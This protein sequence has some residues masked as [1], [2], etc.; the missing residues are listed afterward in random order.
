MKIF[1]KNPGALVVD[2][3]VADPVTVLGASEGTDTTSSSGNTLLKVSVDAL[4]FELVGLLVVSDECTT[5]AVAMLGLLVVAA[6][7]SPGAT[8]GAN[9]EEDKPAPA[10]LFLLDNDGDDDTEAK[11]LPDLPPGFNCKSFQN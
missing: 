7:T 3:V 8:R 2:D 5:S 11:V 1:E 9:V 10:A 4:G 6:L